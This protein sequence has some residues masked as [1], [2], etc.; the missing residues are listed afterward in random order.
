M[1]LRTRLVLLGAVM[2]TML[3]VVAILVAGL[4]FERVMLAEHDR[5]LLGQGA[6]EAVSLFDR[7]A[8]PHL[9]LSESPLE[10]EM[11]DLGELERSVIERIAQREMLATNV[12]GPNTSV[13]ST[14]FGQITSQANAPRQLQFGLKLLW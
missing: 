1:K 2:P 8:A 3:L 4:V 9:H 14:T 13:T 5:A 10:R 11:G 12:G 6:V 7:A